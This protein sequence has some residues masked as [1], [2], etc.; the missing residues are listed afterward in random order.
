[1]IDVLIVD[2]QAI[3]REGLSLMLSLHDDINICGECA[4][5]QE[6]VEFVAKNKVDIVLIDIRMPNMDGVEATRIIKEKDRE[7]RIL[8]LTTFKE[9]KY[10]FQALSNGADGYMLKDSK[11]EYIVNAIRTVYKGQTL[12]QPEIASIVVKEFSNMYN[13]NNV[14]KEKSDK[15]IEDENNIN[16]RKSEKIKENTNRKKKIEGVYGLLT[17]RETEIAYLVADG[18]SN[19]EIAEKLFISEGTVKNHLSKVLSKVGV[20][21]R[22]QLTLYLNN[23]NM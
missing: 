20:R 7:I 14:N 3:I 4:D 11:S 13:E 2:D 23:I 16:K 5:G 9:D 21:D 8:V 17:E 1:M 19:K 6:A 18:Y 22:T 12:L 15:I 10:V